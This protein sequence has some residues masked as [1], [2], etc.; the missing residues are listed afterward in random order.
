MQILVELGI[1]VTVPFSA[2][3]D[4]ST[5]LTLSVV[6]DSHGN[7]LP[8][9]LSGSLCFRPRSPCLR[10][11]E[12][13]GHWPKPEETIRHGL[14]SLQP[15]IST[16]LLP[17]PNV[18]T[19]LYFDWGHVFKAVTTR[20][21]T[22]ILILRWF[23]R[24]KHHQTPIDPIVIRWFGLILSFTHQYMSRWCPV[25]GWSNSLKFRR[26]FG[27]G[28]S[29]SLA[30]KFLPWPRLISVAVWP[31][32]FFLRPFCLQGSVWNVMAF[33]EVSMMITMFEGASWCF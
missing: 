12:A 33:H 17:L 14:N 1:S 20:S 10:P 16:S 18:W 22:E 25:A 15:P 5:A 7:P 31:L 3:F 26:R 9:H 27:H 11:T 8:K 28:R 4:T 23:P 13:H 24:K 19:L 30:A 6:L 21:S 32:F 29:W 2:F